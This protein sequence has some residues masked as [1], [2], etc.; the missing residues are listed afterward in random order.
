MVKQTTWPRETG[1]L[2][3]GLRRFLRL[4]SSVRKR[5]DEGNV[6]QIGAAG[7]IMSADRVLWP[8]FAV[9]VQQNPAEV[10]KVAEAKGG[11]QLALALVDRHER[12][13]HVVGLPMTGR[14]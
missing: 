7:A 13:N 12:S 5:G 4:T 1:L 11:G 3:N 9:S 10:A 8:V 2:S 6:D 14:M